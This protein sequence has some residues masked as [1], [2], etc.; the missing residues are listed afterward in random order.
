[1]FV[2]VFIFNVTMS[3]SIERKKKPLPISVMCNKSVENAVCIADGDG[4][5]RLW[6]IEDMRLIFTECIYLQR[7]WPLR[8]CRAVSL[9]IRND[10][11]E[12]HHFKRE[13]THCKN[14][15]MLKYINMELIEMEIR[16][17]EHEK[18]CKRYHCQYSWI[19]IDL[20][21]DAICTTLEFR[22]AFFLFLSLFLQTK[23]VALDCR[24][25]SLHKILYYLAAAIK[26]YMVLRCRKVPNNLIPKHIY[27][28][29]VLWIGPWK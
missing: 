5:V 14:I 6:A 4:C 21:F 2:F 23:G 19:A 9:P 28:S 24:W 18:P 22:I 20:R 27:C 26:K 15:P 3:R 11:P 7:P 10:S 17:W 29:F 12:L 25:R 16:N 1:M 13:F 8:K